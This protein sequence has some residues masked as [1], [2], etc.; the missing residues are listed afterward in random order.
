MRRFGTIWG[1]AV[2]LAIFKSKV[3]TLAD[4]RLADVE[5]VKE[6]LRNGAAYELTAG[7]SLSYKLKQLR[8]DKDLTRTVSG[9][10]VDGLKLSWQIGLGS[11]SWAS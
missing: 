6:L 1:A 11:A 4:D 10:Y 2:P 7:D 8:G 5:A 9:I 3:N